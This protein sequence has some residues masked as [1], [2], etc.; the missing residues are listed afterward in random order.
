MIEQLFRET[1]GFSKIPFETVPETTIIPFY[2]YRVRFANYMIVIFKGSNK[3]LPIVPC[4][5]IRKKRP[6]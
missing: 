2:S 3:T 6:I 4:R 1:A 5:Y